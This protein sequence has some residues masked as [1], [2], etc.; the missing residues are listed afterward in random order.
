MNESNRTKI[1]A[2]LDAHK[3]D[4]F[5]DLAAQIRIPSAKTD[6]AP[7]APFGQGSVDALEDFLKR[8]DRLGFATKNVDNYMGCVDMGDP[9]NCFGIL[10]HLDVVPEGQG[11]IHDPYGAEII[12]GVMY[13]RGTLDDKGP[14]ISALYAMAAIKDAGIPLTGGVRLLLGTDEES[15]SHDMEYFLTKEKLP[16]IAISPDAEYPVVN[17]E[18]GLLRLVVSAQYEAPASG[19]RLLSM[20]GGTRV[21]VVPAEVTALIA[22]ADLAYVQGAASAVTSE[23]EVTFKCEQKGDHIEITAYGFGAHASHPD[24]GKNA[25]SAMLTLLAALPLAE[26]EGADKLRALAKAFPIDGYYGQHAGIRLWD[27]ASGEL[28]VNLGLIQAD[29]ISF[30]ATLDIRYPITAN[31]EMLTMLLADTTGLKVDVQS[32][33]VPHYVSEKS[34][35]VQALLRAYEAETGLTGECLAIGGGTYAREIPGS[36][37]FGCLFPGDPDTM[38]QPEECVE[39]EKVLLNAKVLAAAIV[40][41]CGA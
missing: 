18:K 22:G 3:Q 7:N 15:G 17:V 35:L 21:N 36:V 31:F 39:L 37:S 33:A 41:F 14:A 11:W 38:H 27:D 19:V 30:A 25:A 29:E 2:Y 24:T 20:G 13:G 16:P 6:P 1:H 34:D 26:G 10:A 23:T 28:T 5:D 40:E 8:A 12:D 32:H 4:M 9:E